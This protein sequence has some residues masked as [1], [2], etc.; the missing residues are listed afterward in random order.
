VFE[1]LPCPL[2]PDSAAIVLATASEPIRPAWDISSIS[3]GDLRRRS[4]CNKV[5]GDSTLWPQ[6]LAKLSTIALILPDEGLLSLASYL[7]KI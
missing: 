3:A 7:P 4:L 2:H 6:V 5:R 1:T